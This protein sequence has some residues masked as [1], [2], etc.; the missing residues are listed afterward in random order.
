M[1]FSSL[2]ETEKIFD[3]QVS[4]F[5]GA[6]KYDNIALT[7]KPKQAPEEIKRLREGTLHIKQNC[8]TC[9]ISLI[10]TDVCS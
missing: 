7:H 2:A 3:L 6:T 8:L 10:S 1:F 4:E 5:T 9:S